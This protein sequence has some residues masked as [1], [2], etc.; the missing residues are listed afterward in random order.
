MNL[1]RIS[2]TERGGVGVYDY[3]SSAVVAAE[4][5]EEARRTH[6]GGPGGW[7]YDKEYSYDCHWVEMDK[8]AVELIG[9]A[10]PGFH[11]GV[12]VASFHAG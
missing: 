2:Q 3:Y 7:E 12:V 9:T 5:E 1:Y 11:A 6:P 10:V 8:V 4:S